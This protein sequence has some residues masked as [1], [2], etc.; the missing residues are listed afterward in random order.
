MVGGAGVTAALGEMRAFGPMTPVMLEPVRLPLELLTQLAPVM[1]LSEEDEEA[2]DNVHAVF[3]VMP[4]AAL[5][6]QALR[7]GAFLALELAAMAPTL[8]P[9]VRRVL[10]KLV[11]RMATRIASR[12]QEDGVLD[13]RGGA[14]Q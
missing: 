7:T 12:L 11:T 2:L 14:L 4:K 5:D 6:S 1:E 13:R 9:G 3:D 8:M 10:G